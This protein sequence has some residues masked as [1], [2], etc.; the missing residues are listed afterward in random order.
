MLAWG[1]AAALGA[2]GCAT[3]SPLPQGAFVRDPLGP[4]QLPAAL[5]KRD[6]LPAPPEPEVLPPLKPPALAE[7]GPLQLAEVLRSVESSFPLLYAIQQERE[8]AAGQRLSAEGAFDPTLRSRTTE[9]GG[10]FASTR[11]DT[12]LEQATPFGGI[13]TF[14]GYRV[15]VGNF[16]VYYGDRKTAEGGEFRAGV[17]VPLLQNRETD[18]R[19]TR[20]RAAQ[21]AEQLADPAIRRARLDYFRDAATVYW[22]WQAAGGQYRVAQYLLK[23]ATDRQTL[24]DEQL[25]QG[26]VTENVVVLN[27]RI[28]AGRR[29]TLLA[30]ERSVQEAAFRLSLYLRDA[31]GEPVV[32]KAEWLLPDVIDRTTP[33]PDASPEAIAEATARA[34][35]V[36]PELVR[37]RLEKERRA[38]ELQLATNQ[39]LPQLNVFAAGTQDVGK[40][41]KSFTGT[42]VFDTDRQTG[43]IGA[44]LEVPLPFRNARGLTATARAQLAQLLAQEKFQRDSIAAQVADATSALTLTYQRLQQAREELKQANRVLEQESVRYRAGAITLVELNLQEIAAAEAR[45]KVVALVGTYFAAEAAARAAQGTDGP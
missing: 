6:G 10:T 11:F 25:K 2:S 45:A 16:P 30:T 15:G 12:F 35:E 17:T 33:A 21:I 24:L 26:A 32:P 34:L 31:A 36:R 13:T 19:R 5:V 7:N 8:I 43:E 38:A 27:R 20:V 3:N 23:L 4:P 14:A 42:G 9:Q 18:P 22:Q 40:A 44:F 41:K 28:L 1:C 29:E 39:L 37:F